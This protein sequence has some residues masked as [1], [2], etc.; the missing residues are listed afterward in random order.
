VLQ[1]IEDLLASN[2][3]LPSQINKVI[4]CG[5]AAKMC[6]IQSL[7]KQKF[8]TSQ[9]LN[10]KSPDEIIALGCAK[11]CGIISNSKIK[12][13][14]A[15][16]SFFKSL[17]NPIFLKV[18]SKKESEQIQVFSSNIALPLKKEVNLEFDL[19]DPFLS[20]M[21]SNDKTLATIS[22]KQFNTKE[23]VA[24]FVFKMNETLEI[25]ISESSTGKKI[26]LFLNSDSAAEL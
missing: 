15:Q 13:I 16:D 5:A 11:Q 7:I 22:L 4:L 24:N 10:Q 17:A 12:S 14:S 9:L 2:K 25:T 19:K 18:G 23:I 20:V 26:T 3:I 21:E 1:P 6:K 8:E